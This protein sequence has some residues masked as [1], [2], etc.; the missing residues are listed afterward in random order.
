MKQPRHIVMFSGPDGGFTMQFKALEASSGSGRL[1][2]GCG[3]KRPEREPCFFGKENDEG[4]GWGAPPRAGRHSN[5]FGCANWPGL[6]LGGQGG[7]YV[8]ILGAKRRGALIGRGGRISQLGVGSTSKG[9]RHNTK[10][11]KNIGREL[12]P[13]ETALVM[14]E[15]QKKNMG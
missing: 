12:Q 14:N 13:G 6:A 3:D 1:V 10:T 11:K 4:K 9:L 5:L 15:S 2:V 7:L 8:T